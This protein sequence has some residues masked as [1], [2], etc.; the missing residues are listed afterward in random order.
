MVNT[1]LRVGEDDDEAGSKISPIFY[2]QREKEAKRW[3]KR[4]EKDK[5]K[6]EAKEEIF[7][8]IIIARIII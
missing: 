2:V 4:R 3:G 1:V 7:D 5:R 6:Q 8:L